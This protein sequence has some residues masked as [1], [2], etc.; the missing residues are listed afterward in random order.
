MWPLVLAEEFALVNWL[1][2]VSVVQRGRM[3]GWVLAAVLFAG[4]IGLVA[5]V[6][7]GTARGDARVATI[8]RDAAQA[9]LEAVAAAE[10]ERDRKTELAAGLSVELAQTR[11]VL[12]D[13][14]IKLSRRVANVTTDYLPASTLSLGES[15][16]RTQTGEPVPIPRT[17]FTVGFVR[18]WDTAAAIAVPETSQ[19]ACRVER[20]AGSG[21]AV[22]E[23]CLHDSGISQAEILTNH[24]DNT[25]RCRVIE[26][27]LD[28]YIAWYRAEEKTDAR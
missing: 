28:K 23:G 4:L 18:L 2:A 16:I 3:L 5:G 13:T 22:G 25:I 20:E 24:I 11:Q 10:A 12:A 19:A 1:S 7:L 17:V 21:E 14:Q 6:W 15:E 9:R 8:Q 26:A 27:Q